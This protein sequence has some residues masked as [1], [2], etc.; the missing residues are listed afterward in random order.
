MF[1][2]GSSTLFWGVG[3]EGYSQLGL[4]KV[5]LRSVHFTRRID[6]SSDNLQLGNENSEAIHM[7]VRLAEAAS[8]RLSK[9]SYVNLSNRLPMVQSDKDTLK[10]AVA[11]AI[12]PK[13]GARCLKI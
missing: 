13:G 11:E 8:L 10:N 6:L 1:A 3:D 2:V 5:Q 9:S 12:E 4:S 7:P